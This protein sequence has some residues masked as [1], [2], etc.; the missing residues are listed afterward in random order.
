MTIEGLPEARWTG[1]ENSALSTGVWD[2]TPENAPRAEIGEKLAKPWATEI[3]L[4][5]KCHR[6]LNPQN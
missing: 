5:G 2:I 1:K 3:K 6:N 4:A